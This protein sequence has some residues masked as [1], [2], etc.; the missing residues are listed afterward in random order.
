MNVLASLTCDRYA[1]VNRL[2]TAVDVDNREL[3]KD[4]LDNIIKLNKIIKDINP[5]EEY[6]K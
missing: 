3:I 6:D 5:L 4:L 2:S 1:L